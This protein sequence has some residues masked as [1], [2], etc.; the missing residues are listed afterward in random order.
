MRHDQ[1]RPGD[2]GWAHRY[3]LGAEFRIR[4][5][6]YLPVHQKNG[7][8][9]YGFS[10]QTPQARH[11]HPDQP[12]FLVILYRGVHGF[13]SAGIYFRVSGYER[14]AAAFSAV[15][16]SVLPHIFFPEQDSHSRSYDPYPP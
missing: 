16:S 1:P 12:F 10:F 5:S 9:S 6:E 3:R 15:E 2:Q 4:R 14:S 7:V 13:F 11:G 8:G